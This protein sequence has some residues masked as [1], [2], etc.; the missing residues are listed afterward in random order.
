MESKI[1]LGTPYHEESETLEVE[2]K[3]F[4]VPKS[5]IYDMDLDTIRRFV[6]GEIPFILKEGFLHQILIEYYSIKMFKNISAM[7]NTNGG[8]FIIGIN[9]DGII[10]GIP[11]IRSDFGSYISLIYK[12]LIMNN[13]RTLDDT[14][15]EN[16][17]INVLP[18]KKNPEIIEEMY[19]VHE[20]IEIY[21]EEM[22]KFNEETAIRKIRHR[23]FVEETRINSM[24]IESYLHSYEMRCK[25]AMWMLTVEDTYLSNF[26]RIYSRSTDPPI[27][28]EE[29]DIFQDFIYEKCPITGQTRLEDIKNKIFHQLITNKLETFL[30][31]VKKKD[32]DI[33]GESES[34]RYIK[35]FRN[36][37]YSIICWVTKYRDWMTYQTRLNYIKPIAPL[38]EPSNIYREIMTKLTPM[39]RIWDDVNYYIIEVEIPKSESEVEYYDSKTCTY[40]SS[41]RSVYS[42]GSPC[43]SSIEF[44]F[45]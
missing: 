3:E 33:I 39:A 44:N 27:T 21:K 19:N 37:P 26:Y 43:C 16:I 12:Q 10:T 24:S 18:V 41:V 30:P 7:G 22:Y 31:K 14:F 25:V 20:Q 9:D 4:C 5:T 11:A 15:I 28:R 36:D 42:D 38:R 13:I 17:R 1:I 8:K 2:F 29:Y 23:K 35:V 6:E 32:S 40:T 45:T 34:G